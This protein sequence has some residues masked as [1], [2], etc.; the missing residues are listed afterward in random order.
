M[1]NLALRAL[2][3][4]WILV[5]ALVLVPA[6]K[7]LAQE[8]PFKAAMKTNL[9]QPVTPSSYGYTSYVQTKGQGDGNHHFWDRENSVL[10]AAVG[11]SATADFFVTRA[12]LASGGRELNPVT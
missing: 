5:L 6:G 3:K 7:V 1:T 12:N 9:I 8:S 2:S 11:A 4:R 10:F